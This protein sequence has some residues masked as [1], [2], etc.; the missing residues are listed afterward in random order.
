MVAASSSSEKVLV[1]S[2]VAD[3][4]SLNQERGHTYD[5]PGG[6]LKATMSYDKKSK[7]EKYWVSLE[8]SID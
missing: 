2:H 1:R 3:L 6:P 5:K 4:P 7:E 8:N